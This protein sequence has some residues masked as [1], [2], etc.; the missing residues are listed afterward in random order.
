[1]KRRTIIL[2]AVALI[3]AAGI[4]AWGSLT[5]KTN[6]LFS[7]THTK[8]LDLNTLRDVISTTR[9]KNFTNGTGANQANVIWHDN[10]TLQDPPTADANETLDVN[11]GTLTDAFGD[12][13]TVAKLKAIYVKNNSADANLLIGGA[14]ATQ[15]E[16]FADPCD[17]LKVRPGGEFFLTSPD[18]TGITVG[19][20]SDLK[21]AHDGTGSSS[22][23]YDI[24]LIGVD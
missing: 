14:T 1:M 6:I 8:T 2:I 24:I 7:V 16:L 13:V 11:D 18:A 21:L 4:T 9:G 12:A 20:N 10:R 3:F 19:N 23:T 15:L 5:A 22:L 17:I